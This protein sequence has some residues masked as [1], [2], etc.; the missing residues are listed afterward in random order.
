MTAFDPTPLRP[1]APANTVSSQMTPEKIQSMVH[2]IGQRTNAS[3]LTTRQHAAIA[4]CVPDS[5][6]PWLDAMIQARRRD[7][8]A[9]SALAAIIASSEWADP[10]TTIQSFCVDSYSV[11]DAMLAASNKE[12]GNG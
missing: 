5:G 11:A 4:L 7:E 12:P 9:K 6:T 3:Q 8:M 1:D 2:Q 10:S